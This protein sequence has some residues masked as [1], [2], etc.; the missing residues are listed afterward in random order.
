MQAFKPQGDSLLAGRPRAA[1]G[2]ACQGFGFRQLSNRCV[3]L[4]LGL[5]ARGWGGAVTCFQALVGD[6]LSTPPPPSLTPTP[7]ASRRAY[8]PRH[9][10]G[11]LRGCQHT[12][13]RSGRPTGQAS[14]IAPWNSRMTRRMWRGVAA[15]S[16]ICVDDVVR[17]MATSAA[18]IAM[19]CFI[20]APPLRRG[21][22][23]RRGLLAPCDG[24]HRQ[25]PG[26]HGEQG[27]RVSRVLIRG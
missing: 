22:V 10:V 21:S 25:S 20:A 17:S 12:V 2:K 7:H 11:N 27:F 23:R 5:M 6:S 15:S 1:A 16:A 4:F 3:H 13:G 14:G 18:R 19:A 8:T 26:H 9:G 24:G